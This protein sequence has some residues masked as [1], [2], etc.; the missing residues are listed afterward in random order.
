[1]AHSSRIARSTISLAALTLATFTFTPRAF[2][3]GTDNAIS[4]VDAWTSTVF[5]Q[6]Q[7][8][9]SGIGLRTRLANATLPH[10]EFAPTIEYWR[11]ASNVTEFGIRT[12]RRDATLTADALYRFDSKS[13][14]HPYVGAGL[15]LHFLQ[16]QVDAPR[17]G[18]DH[19]QDSVVRAGL[20]AMAGAEFGSE[21]FGNFIEVKYHEIAGY[22]QFKL[23]IGMNWHLG[24]ASKPAAPAGK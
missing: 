4:G 14:I 13:T 3:A 11:N 23:N 12:V 17:L 2:A 7:S 19:K 16:S 21:R 20:D 22:R 18:L 24:V 9:F 1:V 15:G 10:V 5:Q 8:S 6:G